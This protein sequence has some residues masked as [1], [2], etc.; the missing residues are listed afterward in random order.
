MENTLE[1]KA[2]Y[3]AQYWGQ[4]V[5]K[6]CTALFDTFGLDS[7]LQSTYT[8]SNSS[9]L[10]LKPLSSIT[11]EDAMDVSKIKGWIDI[12]NEKVNIEATKRWLLENDFLPENFFLKFSYILDYLRSK[13]YALPFMGLSVEQL[14][15][16]GWLKLKSN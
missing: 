5:I 10:E 8:I 14:I 13:G 11:D 6:N 15:E 7:V 16:Y 2:K 3:F 4:D 12:L 1:N 9:Y